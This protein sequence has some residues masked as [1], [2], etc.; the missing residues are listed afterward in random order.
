MALAGSWGCHILLPSA[1][2]DFPLGTFFLES[3]E[4]FQNIVSSGTPL[5]SVEEI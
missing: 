1:T 3:A 5:L 2:Q 4:G